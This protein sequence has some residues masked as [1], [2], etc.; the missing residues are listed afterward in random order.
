[1]KSFEEYLIM[2]GIRS[3][4]F[5]YSDKDIFDNILYF[6]ECYHNNMSAYNALNNF[7]YHLTNKI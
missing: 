3:I 1:M 2:V 4:D 7:Y 6:R 5:T